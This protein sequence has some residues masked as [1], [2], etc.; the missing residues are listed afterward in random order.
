MAYKISIAT[1]WEVSDDHREHTRIIA[2]LDQATKDYEAAIAS[3]SGQIVVVKIAANRL[4]KKA[5][6]AAGVLAAIVQPEDGLTAF[7]T[8]DGR[9]D[10]TAAE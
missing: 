6:S 1:S 5:E 4:P 8:K 9:T 3:V 2:G 7:T 10:R